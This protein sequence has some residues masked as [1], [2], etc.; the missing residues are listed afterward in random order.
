[1]SIT[2]IGVYT[3]FSEGWGARI[4]LIYQCVGG[5]NDQ[6]GFSGLVKSCHDRPHALQWSQE[7]N[8]FPA[9][10]EMRWCPAGKTGPTPP[11]HPTHKLLTPLCKSGSLILYFSAELCSKISLL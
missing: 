4:A 8:L 6:Q 2:C 7:L 1:M 9:N 5:K 11:A 10:R 3:C